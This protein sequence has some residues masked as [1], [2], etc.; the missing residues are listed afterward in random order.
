MR[1]SLS[2]LS[3]YIYENKIVFL[4]YSSVKFKKSAQHLAQILSTSR[5]RKRQNRKLKKKSYSDRQ[6]K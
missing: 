2:Y 6:I 1:L 4:L 3:Q 5:L